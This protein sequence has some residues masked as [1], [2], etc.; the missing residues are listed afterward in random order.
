MLESHQIELLDENLSKL[1]K[2]IM[3]WIQMEAKSL[4][5]KDIRPIKEQADQIFIS[6][7]GN[8]ETL[9]QGYQSRSKQQRKL[10]GTLTKQ[11]ILLKLL[12]QKD[13]IDFIPM[14]EN[15]FGS[16]RSSLKGYCRIKRSQLIL[17]QDSNPDYIQGLLKSQL[18]CHKVKRATKL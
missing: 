8:I 3:T 9:I 7:L 13:P 5:E 18:V 1:D 15:L 16:K 10:I 6:N 17:I 2:L 11:I 14:A 4:S 12:N